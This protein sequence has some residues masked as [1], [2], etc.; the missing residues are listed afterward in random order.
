MG[1]GLARLPKIKP[2]D[3]GI[4]VACRP[5]E[6]G[7]AT[8]AIVVGARPGDGACWRA[9]ARG[10]RRGPQRPGARLL[11]RGARRGPL[12]RPNAINMTFS[13]PGG[14]RLAFSEFCHYAGLSVTNALNAFISA[15]LAQGKIPFEIT[16][17]PFCSPSN[18]MALAAGVFAARAGAGDF[19][20]LI[21]GLQDGRRVPVHARR[22]ARAQG[23]PRHPGRDRAAVPQGRGGLQ[24]LAGTACT[25]VFE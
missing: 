3:D 2:R 17:D 21:A 16:G 25:P 5:E 19:D 24:A 20:D 8:R 18:A 7:G 10:R 11:V 1:C 22:P 9:A 23:H 14:K 13:L 15:A 6:A 12:A 4:R